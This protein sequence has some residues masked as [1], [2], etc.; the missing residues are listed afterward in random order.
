[1]LQRLGK[2]PHLQEGYG[3]NQD[4][5]GTQAPAQFLLLLAYTPRQAVV[6]AQRCTSGTKWS[7][8]KSIMQFAIMDVQGSTLV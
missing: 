2:Q 1:M 4:K 3:H 7:I 8:R 5:V 6:R